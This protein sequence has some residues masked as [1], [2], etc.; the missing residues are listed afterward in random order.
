MCV[1]KMSFGRQLKTVVQ[2]KYHVIVEQSDGIIGVA[3]NLLGRD[4]YGKLKKYEPNGTYN[5][6]TFLAPNNHRH[7]EIQMEALVLSRIREIVMIGS[8]FN[9]FF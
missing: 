6:N 1:Q 7:V 9:A 3:N 4:R 2:W 8:A 5:N